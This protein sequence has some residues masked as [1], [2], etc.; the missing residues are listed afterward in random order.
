MKSS[1]L[2]IH[3]TILAALLGLAPGMAFAQDAED[4]VPEVQIFPYETTFT[5]TAYYSPIEGQKRYIKGSLEADKKL[6]GNGTHGADGTPVFPGMIAAPKT[7][8]FG[9]KM[10]IP[11]IGTVAVHDRGGAIVP[12]GERGQKF[13]RLDVWMGSGDEGLNRAL[14]WG[15]RN[16]KVVVYGVDAN[17]EEN[18]D[19]SSISSADLPGHSAAVTSVDNPADYGLGDQDSEITTLKQ[20]FQKLGYF[21]GAVSDT[22]DQELY[23]AVLK[24]QL[25]YEIIDSNNDFGAG[26]FGPQTRKVMNKALSGLSPS[27]NHKEN[28]VPVA[29]AAAGD[30]QSEKVLLAGNG[31]SFL[32]RDLQLGDSGQA[33][34]ELQTELKKLN[35]FGIEP[36]GY[37]G[38][39]TAHA[40]FKFQQ[41][42]GLIASE[43]ALGAGTAG[44]STRQ[45]LAA[46]LNSRVDT[47]RI[48]A[49][50]TEK[51]KFLASK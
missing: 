1:S 2:K 35:L 9:T 26:F 41:S 42:R 44:P 32:D 28:L 25:D 47:R 6:N 49:E 11:G 27:T 40:V 51:D 7:I 17:I 5:I 13:N 46:I 12:A 10:L 8:P 36:T 29:Q 19:L 38:E 22:F 39:V 45:E 30:A 34:L 50:N 48:I 20:N 18:I 31:L 23:N 16:V 14:R 4:S 3:L 24:F 21:K 43:T 33:V 15:R 37:Y